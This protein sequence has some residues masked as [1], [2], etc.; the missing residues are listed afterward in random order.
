MFYFSE[1]SRHPE[2]LSFSGLSFTGLSFQDSRGSEFFGSPEGPSFS[3]LL[4]GGK[5]NENPAFIKKFFFTA[6][7]APDIL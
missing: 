4:L 6:N 1:L 5:K 3:S 2:G 7:S